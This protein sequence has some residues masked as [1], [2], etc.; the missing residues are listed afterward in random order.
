[1]IFLTYTELNAHRHKIGKVK[2]VLLCDYVY[3]LYNIDNIIINIIAKFKDVNS[4]DKLKEK[5]PLPF[6]Q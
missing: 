2:S 5:H 4:L 1:M 6:P 3:T